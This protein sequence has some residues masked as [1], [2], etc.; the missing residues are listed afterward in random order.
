MICCLA[1]GAIIHDQLLLATTSQSYYNVTS[2]SLIA[3]ADDLAAPYTSAILLV[4]SN[5]AYRVIP[6]SSERRFMQAHTQGEFKGPLSLG[7]KGPLNR[8][9]YINLDFLHKFYEWDMLQ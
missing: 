4:D 7:H 6:G 5:L 9:K 2:N 1:I 8:A 3:A